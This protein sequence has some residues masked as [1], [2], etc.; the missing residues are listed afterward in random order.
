M[1]DMVYKDV[2]QTLEQGEACVVLTLI[3]ENAKKGSRVAGKRFLSCSGTRVAMDACIHALSVTPFDQA[4]DQVNGVGDPEVDPLFAQEAVTLVE[5]SLRSGRVA[6]KRVSLEGEAAR[7]LAEPFYPPDEL[8]ILGGGHVSQALVPVAVIL[9]YRVTVVDDRP[10]FAAPER[11]PGAAKVICD[12]FVR[13][14]EGLHLQPSC[15]V[16]IITRGHRHDLRC[17]EALVGRQLG[18]LGMI[19]SRRRVQLIKEHLRSSGVSEEKIERVQ[20]PIGLP[21]GAQTPEEIAVSIAAQLI[22]ARRGEGGSAGITVQDMELLRTLVDSAK[23]GIP[24]V[25]ATVV[26]ARGSTPRKAGAKLLVFRDG[27]MRGTIGGG[28]IEAEARREALLLLDGGAAGL[29]RFSLDDDAAAEEGMACGGTMEV[30]LELV[31][32]V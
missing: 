9:G 14:I 23:R 6:S 7:L 4:N 1:V 30:L 10:A 28:C 21:I 8:V 27:Q 29:F 15:A 5:A 26:E 11:F 3:K 19:G 25:L 22:Q 17:L 18:Y 12:D 20:M 24:A 13:A 32:T 16:A 31:A 2:L